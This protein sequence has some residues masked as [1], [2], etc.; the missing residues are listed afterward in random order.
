MG[1]SEMAGQV[2]IPDIVPTCQGTA[3][4]VQKG[5][6]AAGGLQGPVG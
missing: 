6:G 5:S 3:L 1:G 2:W 4:P